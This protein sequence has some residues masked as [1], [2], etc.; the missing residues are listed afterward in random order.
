M[1][2][3]IM[4]LL[5]VLAALTLA[6]CGTKAVSGASNAGGKP[7]DPLELQSR[8]WRQSC[9]AKRRETPISREE[10]PAR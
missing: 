10:F 3:M 7:D 1:K 9:W 6:A 2:R 4:I 8:S 5:T